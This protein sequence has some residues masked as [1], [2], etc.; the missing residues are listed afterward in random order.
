MNALADPRVVD[1]FNDNFICTYLKVGTFQI[2]N[3]K[4]VGGN[5]ASY[6]C[7]WD[8]GVLHAV[9][10]KVNADKLLD[11]ARWAYETRKAALTFGTNLA[12]GDLDMKKYVEL[13]RRAHHERFNTALDTFGTG[14]HGKS[15]QPIPVSFPH[16]LGQQAQAHWLLA[17]APLAKLDT[18]YPQV[19]TQILH[20]QLSTLPVSKR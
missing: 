19:W 9:P 3:G 4:K 15:M 16:Q 17:K 6:F 20:E 5:V 7:L 14:R 11:E 18:I 1:Y 13:V 12:K 8:G 10:G 2:I